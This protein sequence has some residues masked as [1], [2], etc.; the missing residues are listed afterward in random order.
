MAS[1]DPE[2]TREVMPDFRDARRLKSGIKDHIDSINPI[3][4]T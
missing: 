2:D 1:H 3:T 4:F